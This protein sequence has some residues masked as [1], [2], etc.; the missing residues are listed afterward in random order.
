MINHT[1]DEPLDQRGRVLLFPNSESYYRKEITQLLEDEQYRAAAEHL[2]QLL[3][4]E[5]PGS[6]Q[7]DEWKKLLLALQPLLEE[8]DE[9]YDSEAALVEAELH[10]RKATHREYAQ[11]LF[12]DLSKPHAGKQLLALQQLA[13]LGDERLGDDLYKWL[14]AQQ[15]LHP[16]VQYQALR[17][18]K[19]MG[20][21]GE[22]E[23]ERLGQVIELR[24]QDI[25]L[26]PEEY[27]QASH[28]VLK[29]ITAVNEGRD[30]HLMFLAEPTWFEFIT[31]IYG[32]ASYNQMMTA[33]EQDLSVW[34]AAL[35]V[36]VQE[37]LTGEAEREEILDWYAIEEGDFFKWHEAHRQLDHFV[38]SH[39]QSF[40]EK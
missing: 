30:P 21:S 19:S 20:K 26:T 38:Q 3:S 18:L 27:P 15:K 23:L 32:T 16:S 34:A 39:R 29:A 9:R 33:N 5:T 40:T 35:H 37:S 11:Q 25:P 28:D 1:E 24:I 14:N 7:R 12:E 31:Y 13:Y 10:S 22:I 8:E 6:L 17:T 4:F 2:E 36:V